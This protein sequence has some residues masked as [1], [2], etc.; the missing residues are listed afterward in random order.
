MTKYPMTKEARMTNDEECIRAFV[1]HHFPIRHS[2]F[3][4]HSSLGTSSFVI[5]Q[6][7]T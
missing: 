6:L 3:V 7:G 1:D 5:V 2:S 4:I